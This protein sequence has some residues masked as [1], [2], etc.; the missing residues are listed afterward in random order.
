MKTIA[1]VAEAP[2]RVVVGEYSLREPRADEVVIA[3]AYS[4]ISPGTELRCLAGREPN[5]QRFPMITG[6]SL[7][8]TI[9]RGA[10][11]FKPGDRVFLN[12]ASVCPDGIASAW[13]G[14]IQYAIAPVSQVVR[15]PAGV[16]LKAA[17]ALSML[18]IAKIGRAHV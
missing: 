12:G 17:S 18:S 11:D 3:T 6:Y 16:D 7:A 8:G 10:G 13:G 14:H 9:L 1:V 4:T 5:A 15:L 2:N